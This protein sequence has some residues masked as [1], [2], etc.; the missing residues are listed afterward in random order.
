MVRPE[1]RP[2]NHRVRPNYIEEI[3]CRLVAQ[4]MSLGGSRNFSAPFINRRNVGHSK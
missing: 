2:I 4:G 3:L 1:P